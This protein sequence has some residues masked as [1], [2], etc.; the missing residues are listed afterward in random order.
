MRVYQWKN[1]HRRKKERTLRGVVGMRACAF[2][3]VK[4]CEVR[5]RYRGGG[6]CRGG[7]PGRVDVAACE[8][9]LCGISGRT[10]GG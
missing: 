8:R 4:N 3:I 10:V 1:T 7:F 9:F 5:E 6:V 2:P